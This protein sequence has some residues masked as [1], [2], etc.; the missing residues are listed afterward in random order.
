[1][2]IRPEDEAIDEMI[3]R[4]IGMLDRIDEETDIDRQHILMYVIEHV[5]LEECD[6]MV[7][8]RGVLETIQQV[9][10]E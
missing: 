9:A 8:V 2:T 6:S 1:M 3:V 7:E 10:G 5:L 4:T